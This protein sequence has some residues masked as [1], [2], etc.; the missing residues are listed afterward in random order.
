MIGRLPVA[1]CACLLMLP[2]LAACGGDDDDGGGTPT[3]AGGS[4]AVLSATAASSPGSNDSNTSPV[5]AMPVS[6]YSLSIEDLGEGFGVEISETFVLDIRTYGGTAAFPSASEG[7][8]LLSKWGYLG[9]YETAYWPEG[10]KQAELNGAY[11]VSIEC[12]LFTDETG[13]KAAYAYFVDHLAKL[14][15]TAPVNSAPVGNESKSFAIKAGKVASSTINEIYHRYAFRRGNFVAIVQTIG[16]EPFMR[17]ETA[18][19]VAAIMDAKILGTRAAQEP[20]PTSNYQTAK[21]PTPTR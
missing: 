16:A 18:R 20:T 9:G 3:E 17:I 12:H 7:Q 5:V 8:K 1:L 15:N 14:A 2:L 4:P 19:G 6:K 21:S 13:A 10:R 11:F